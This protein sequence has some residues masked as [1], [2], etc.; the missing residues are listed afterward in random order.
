MQVPAGG[1]R[2]AMGIQIGS[3]AI[4]MPE[5]NFTVDVGIFVAG[6]TGRLS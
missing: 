6:S 5:R 4:Y 2:D 1:R 3:D